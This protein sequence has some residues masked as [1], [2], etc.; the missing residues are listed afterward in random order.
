[1]NA[2]DWPQNVHRYAARAR[3]FLHQKYSEIDDYL[4]FVSDL[5]TTIRSAY[6]RLLE[7][8]AQYRQIAEYVNR[9]ASFIDW[10][11]DGVHI[12]RQLKL[13]AAH[14]RQRGLEQLQQTAV[15]ARMRYQLDKTYFRF[16]ADA[17][18]ILLEQKLPVPW[19]SWLERPQ[20][21][22]LA[23][24]QR[25]DSLLAVFRSSNVTMMDRFKSYLPAPSS[26]WTDWLPPF[27]ASAHLIGMQNY[28]TFDGRS[29]E[30]S[31]PCTYLLSRD[32]YGRNFSLAVQYVSAKGK[33]FAHIVH[34]V[35]DEAAWQLDLSN[36]TVRLAGA[37]QMLPVQERATAAYFDSHW[38]VI[39]SPARGIHLQCDVRHH[40]CTFTLSG[41]SSCYFHIILTY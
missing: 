3:A 18:L 19:N 38:L 15:D 36:N 35:V 28:V 41:E 32:F 39:E 33:P 21:R 34:L 37:T 17:G 30:V 31:G 23:E 13:F 24:I 1:M 9:A 5:N 2:A 29:F 16:E 22:Q 25:I 10:A 14:L 20:W 7:N 26:G 6:V 27:K 12:G 4:A 8:N 11:L 40:V